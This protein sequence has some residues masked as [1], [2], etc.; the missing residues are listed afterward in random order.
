MPFLCGSVLGS[1]P[2]A[3]CVL[4]RQLSISSFALRR[5]TRRFVSRAVKADTAVHYARF[6][7][8]RPLGRES[9]VSSVSTSIPKGAHALV[10]V[11]GRQNFKAP[12]AGKARHND[13][14]YISLR[15]L[16]PPPPE[17]LPW[18][19]ELQKSLCHVPCLGVGQL[20]IRCLYQWTPTWRQHLPQ[21][22][23]CCQRS[24]NKFV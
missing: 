5:P 10:E 16:T 13:T 12:F 24:N 20:L 3:S 17:G 21:T 14:A 7:G 23:T 15:M 2:F 9:G 19:P 8:R 6:W 22:C 18:M 11:N 1:A 4:K